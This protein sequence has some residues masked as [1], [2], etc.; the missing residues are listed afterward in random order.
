[1]FCC[2]RQ[3]NQYCCR[4]CN[5]LSD[6]SVSKIPL[7]SNKHTL[8]DVIEKSLP[9]FMT[10]IFNFKLSNAIVIKHHI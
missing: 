2:N 9:T 1:M 5:K 6:I 7:F 3:V 4:L 10:A 8:S